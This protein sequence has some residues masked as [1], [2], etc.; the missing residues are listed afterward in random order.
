MRNRMV[1]LSW[2]IS[3]VQDKGDLQSTFMSCQRR[4]LAREG[5]DVLIGALATYTT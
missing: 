5:V 2:G 3:T 1:M 4:W